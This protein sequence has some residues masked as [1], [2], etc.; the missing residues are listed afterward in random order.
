MDI[1][2]AELQ[3]FLDD[4]HYGWGDERE[5]DHWRTEHVADND[6]WWASK[7]PAAPQPTAAEQIAFLRSGD[8]YRQHMQQTNSSGIYSEPAWY[9]QR[10]QPQQP[11]IYSDEPAYQGLGQYKSAKAPSKWLPQPGQ[12]DQDYVAKMKGIVQHLGQQISGDELEAVMEAYTAA[13]ERLEK[14]YTH[15]DVRKRLDAKTTGSDVGIFGKDARQLATQVREHD[16]AA[17]NA[18]RT[19]PTYQSVAGNVPSVNIAGILAAEEQARA[20][21]VAARYAHNLARPSGD[22]LIVSTS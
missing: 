16:Q 20:D 12:S 15:A 14:G 17:A 1:A 3:D 22:G 9:G 8:A 19:A 5:I 7:L 10:P 13:V 11:S 18:L 6:N 2:P 21:A 4:V